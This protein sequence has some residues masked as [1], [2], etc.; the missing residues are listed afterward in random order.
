M[1]WNISKKSLV[2]HGYIHIDVSVLFFSI[3]KTIEFHK[4]F[5]SCNN[6]PTLRQLMPPN[7]LNQSQYWADYCNAYA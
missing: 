2:A 7:E 6:D 5:Q 3:D 4:E 1:T